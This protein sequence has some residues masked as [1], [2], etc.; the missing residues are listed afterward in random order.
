MY[1][2]TDAGASWSAV[3]GPE[4]VIEVEFG[5]ADPGVA[6]AL[7]RDSCELVY[8]SG[9]TGSSWAVAGPDTAI[10][11]SQDLSVDPRNSDVAWVNS[12]RGVVRTTDRGATWRFANRGIRFSHCYTIG[13]NPSDGRNLFV[14]A[15]ECRVFSTADRGNTWSLCTGFWCIENGM[16]SDIEVA[17]EPAGPILYAFEGYG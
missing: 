8:V 6:Y 16:C 5:T 17:P 15:N 9:D 7:G 14:G 10:W 11:K 12:Y 3:S 13:V 1:R 2:S 4:R